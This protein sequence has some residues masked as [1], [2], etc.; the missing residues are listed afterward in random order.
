MK[1]DKVLLFFNGFIF[2]ERYV[3]LILGQI[4]LP[5]LNR[6]DTADIAVEACIE[7]FVHTSLHVQERHRILFSFRQNVPNVNTFQIRYHTK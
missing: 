2:S 5:E 7:D 4:C 6:E 1:I 3:T